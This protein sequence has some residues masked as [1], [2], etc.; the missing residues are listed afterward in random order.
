MK[1]DRLIPAAIIGLLTVYL[2]WTIWQPGG[3]EVLLYLTHV[4]F[5]ASALLASLLTLK[6]ARTFEPGMSSRYVWLLL[7]AG[8][9]VLTFSESLWIVYHVLRQPQP[10]PSVVDISWGI[11]FLPMLASLVLH[12]RTL[13]VQLSRCQK[14]LMLAAY[15]GILFS[16]LLLSLEYILS[17]PGEVVI[18]Q[19]LIGAYYLI[20]NLGVAF[21][22]VL[23]LMYLGGGL[24]ARPWV[25]LVSSILMF[26]VGGLAFSYGTWSGTYATG[27]NLL[28]VVSDMAYLAGYLLAAA[29]AYTQLTLRLPVADEE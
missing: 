29:G 9:M 15:L 11:G 18:M 16:V 8:L 7:S 25:Y 10:Y 19:L 20:G 14:L 21:L 4:A 3:S 6:A 24:V 28:S 12:Y 22:A 13:H 2:A 17:H 1:K 26:A 5:A 27:A 23:S